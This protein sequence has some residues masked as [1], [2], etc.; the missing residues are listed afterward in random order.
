MRDFRGAVLPA[1]RARQADLA[2]LPARSLRSLAGELRARVARGESPERSPELLAHAF[3]LAAEAAN[4]TLALSPYDSQLEGALALH[5]GMVAE[6]A[7]GEGKTLVATLPAFL[8]ALDPSSPAHVVTA[9]DYLAGRDAQWMGPLYRFLGLEVGAVRAGDPPERR[10]RAYGADVCYVA[11]FELGWDYLRDHGSAQR[12]GERVLVDAGRRPGLA[13]IDEVDSVLIDEARTPLMLTRG[14]E[15]EEGGGAGSPSARLVRAAALARRLR[16][17]EHFKLDRKLKQVEIL[18]EGTHLA[19]ELLEVPSLWG[20]S[21]RGAA[22]E[23]APPT[24][25]GSQAGQSTSQL[26]WGGLLTT[27][28]R[29][30]HCFLRD[31]DYVVDEEARQVVLIDESTGRLRLQ[32]RLTDDLHSALEAK[33]GLP[34]RWDGQPESSIT[35]QSLFRGLYPPGRL[36]GMTGTAAPAALELW[37]GLGVPVHRVAPHRPCVRVDEPVRLWATEEAKW[38]DSAREV[39]SAHARGQPVLVGTGSVA[40]SELL[41][42]ILARDFGVPHRVL[43]ARPELAASEASVVAQAGRRAAVTIATNMAGRGTDILLGGNAAARAKE[44]LEAA[45]LTGSFRGATSAGGGDDHEMASPGVLDEAVAEA[46]SEAGEASDSRAAL[47]DTALGALARL[48]AVSSV[49]RGEEG[50]TLLRPPHRTAASAE[51]EYLEEG[52]DPLRPEGEVEVIA[53]AAIALAARLSSSGPATPGASP[54]AEALEATAELRPDGCEQMLWAAATRAGAQL[55][56]DCRAAS[57][58]EAAEVRA[59]GGLLVV[60]TEIHESRRVDLQLRGRAGRQGDPGRTKLIVSAQD[61]VM[62]TFGVESMVALLP[63]LAVNDGNEAGY[64]QG[65][66]IDRLVV[67]LQRNTDG[68]YAN[69][70]RNYQRY[71]EVLDEQRQLLHDLRTRILESPG[72]ELRSAFVAPAFLEAVEGVLAPAAAGEGGDAATPPVP[73]AE[74]CKSGAVGEAL[75]ALVGDA[76]TS[77]SAVPADADIC[78]AAV[79]LARASGRF[80]LPFGSKRAARKAFGRLGW[81]DGR[82]TRPDPESEPELAALCAWF[83][84]VP[85]G[86][87]P[88]RTDSLLARWLAAPLFAAYA[89]AAEERLGGLEALPPS[90]E[91]PGGLTGDEAP[92]SFVTYLERSSVL[93]ALDEGW[94]GHLIA[95]TGIRTRTSIGTFH[96]DDPLDLFKGELCE[97]FDAMLDGVGPRAAALLLEE[98][99]EYDAAELLRGDILLADRA[100]EAG[101]Q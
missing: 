54:Q 98:V 39:A 17:G 78:R 58:R 79:E 36:A 92:E 31:K 72:P 74:R 44:L 43:N 3:A 35:V 100:P 40:D 95:V 57:E 76:E 30:R 6:M 33:E 62:T 34:V 50:G 45:L 93:R 61:R 84:D 56:A 83:T 26:N 27:A 77:L 13:I 22:G 18:P 12:R 96:E 9:N 88:L 85:K 21:T 82:C 73:L 37:R 25:G 80:R 99:R 101:L 46:L 70:R 69:M 59:C 71:D 24:G 49:V 75:R 41:S 51:L 10:R 5:R 97:N 16:E 89:R 86:A 68:W 4:R 23:A 87:P 91:G 60:G 81:P 32:S 20:G 38:A 19:Q 65:E 14:T 15:E 7:T 8:N 48:R 90:G 29:A 94:K 2:G 63:K 53:E 64:S 66:F 11:A 1:V 67:S 55:L 28:L 47:S 42:E 52:P